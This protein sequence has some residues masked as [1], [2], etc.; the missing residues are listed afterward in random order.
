MF[1]RRA[2]LAFT[3]LAVPI[4]HAADPLPTPEQI[5]AMADAKDWPSLLQAT[6]RTLTL[7]GAI[8]EPYDRVGLWMKKAEAQLHLNQFVPA[9]QSMAKAA[10]EKAAAPEQIDNALALSALFRHTDAKGYKSSARLGPIKLYDVKEPAG[11]RDALA[12]L[13]EGGYADVAQEIDRIKAAVDAKALVPLAKDI[14]ELRAIDRV[15]NK[16]NEKSDTLEK[17]LADNFADQARKWVKPVNERLD[18]LAKLGDERVEVQ[19]PPDR[20]G[21]VTISSH[22]RGNTPDE[23]AELKRFTDQAKKFGAA[24]VTLE[25]A[26]GPV[27]KAAIKPVKDV[28]EPA[29]ERAK[30]L[31]GSANR[32]N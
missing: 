14:D 32:T 8:A 4:A 27:G 5:Q 20:L 6:N 10:A 26:L 2:A 13:F 16:S 25:P 29:Y 24:Y 12:A 17:T 28:V 7:K 23:V 1:S 30:S 21:R 3:L 11:R 18:A 9:S 15:V 19:S 22:R 31:T